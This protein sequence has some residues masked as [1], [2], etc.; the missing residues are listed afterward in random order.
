[1]SV[2]MT[3]DLQGIAELQRKLDRL[4]KNIRSYVEEALSNEISNIRELAQSLAPKRTGFLA[5]TVFTEKTGEWTFKLGAKATYAYFVEFGTRFM[6]A[7]RFLTRALESSKPSLLL[8]VNQ[9]LRQA[10]TEASNT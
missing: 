8:R 6:K 2:E 1:M 10:I 9:T 5:S 4:D 3:V 7:R